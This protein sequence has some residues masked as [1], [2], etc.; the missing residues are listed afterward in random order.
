MASYPSSGVAVYV[1]ANVTGAPEAASSAHVVDTSPAAWTRLPLASRIS[2]DE[3]V[4]MSPHRRANAESMNSDEAPLSSSSVAVTPLIVPRSLNRLAGWLRTPWSSS[5]GSVA[6]SWPRV[7]SVGGMAG[8]LNV[9]A[10]GVAIGD[11]D[12]L[13]VSVDESEGECERVVAMDGDGEC[14]CLS[15]AR[16]AARA[17]PLDAWRRPA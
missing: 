4:S 1:D 5:G 16:C 2:R 12:G 6:V 14:E 11:G 8:V 17:C 7:E 15:D 3:G 9:S 13:M 10:G